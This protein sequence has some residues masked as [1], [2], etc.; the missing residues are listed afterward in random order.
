M[1]SLF[2]SITV[3]IIY[4][5]KS[6]VIKISI[7]SQHF[8]LPSCSE[9]QCDL[10]LNRCNGIDTIPIVDDDGGLTKTVSVEDSFIR[11]SVI[12]IDSVREKLSLLYGRLLRLL[13]QRRNISGNPNLSYPRSM[14][15]SIR[16]VDKELQN[17]GRKPFRTISKQSN[18]NGNLLLE[19][20]IDDETKK[21]HIIHSAASSLLD[22]LLLK[23]DPVAGIN[24]TRLN[25]A[26]ISFADI[27][28]VDL[29]RKHF[30]QDMTR[31]KNL[32]D[33]FSMERINTPI[34]N[35]PTPYRHEQSKKIDLQEDV[36]HDAHPT[37][38]L[39]INHGKDETDSQQP[40]ETPSWVDPSVF[41]ALPK[42]IA[43][44]VMTHQ[45]LHQ[46]HNVQ[47]KKASKGIQSFFVKKK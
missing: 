33:Y 11:G 14:R 10:L 30:T 24:V 26:V 46:Q 45:R 31:E 18:F 6:I 35:S 13:D 27:S 25:L 21:E 12:T 47:K 38:R 4:P 32:S 20:D 44:E 36:Q 34:F 9:E 37:K 16:F 28:I 19:E 42:D 43:H 17:K 22:Q 41:A 40:L 1:V 8:E 5:Y 29:G 39:K 3:V 15:I 2:Y 7:L 23:L